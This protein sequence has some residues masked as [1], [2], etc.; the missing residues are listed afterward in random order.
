MDDNYSSGLSDGRSGMPT[1]DGGI[2]YQFGYIEGKRARERNDGPAGAGIGVPDSFLRAL[3]DLSV[4]GSKRGSG[5]PGDLSGNRH[6]SQIRPA[7]TACTRRCR[8][9]LWLHT[10]ASRR[11]IQA[12]PN[13]PRR[14]P[15]GGRPVSMGEHAG[16][17]GTRRA[18]GRHSRGLPSHLR[19][20]VL[21]DEAGRPSDGIQWIA[22][23]AQSPMRAGY[24][25]DVRRAFSSF[26]STVYSGSTSWM[27]GARAFCA[28]N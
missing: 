26:T 19:V 16:R 25:R 3:L 7:C 15:V 4:G 20:S 14:C 28:T 9:V 22:G 27:M 17:H 12:V 24:A 2:G 10:R 5:W 21:A 11:A 6:I 18:V 8:L 13:L 1:G 23:R